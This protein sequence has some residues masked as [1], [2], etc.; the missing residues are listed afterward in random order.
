MLYQCLTLL[1]CEVI[2]IKATFKIEGCYWKDK[3]FPSL[4]NYISEL[5]RNPKEGGRFKKRYVNIACHC[6]S[7]D[8]GQWHTENRV[9]LHYT[10]AEPSKGQ[11]RDFDNVC[12]LAQKF[13]LDALRDMNVIPDDKPTYVAG[14]DFKFLYTDD[15]PYIEVEI[16]EILNHE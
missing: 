10:F 11:K 4:N 8:L 15:E 9:Y 6:I 1:K 12:G 7:Q 13:I 3:C 14:F 2:K 5:G 16:E